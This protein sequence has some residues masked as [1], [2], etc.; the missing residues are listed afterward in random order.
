[1]DS[2]NNFKGKWALVTGASAG[3]GVAL[4][5]E[6]AKAGAN[7]VLTARRADRME[8]LAA[9]LLRDLRNVAEIRR[10]DGQMRK[11]RVD[12]RGRRNRLPVSML[13]FSSEARRIEGLSHG[14][15]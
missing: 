12:K 8:A 9:E 6:L 15:I 4:A 7:L 11:P 14:K 10:H 2:M 13:G 1:M 3:I 5:R